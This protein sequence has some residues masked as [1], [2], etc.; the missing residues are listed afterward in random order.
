M[1]GTWRDGEENPEPMGL[2]GDDDE[3]FDEG[4]S[5]VDPRLRNFMALPFAGVRKALELVLLAVWKAEKFWPGV[6]TGP[7]GDMLDCY[8]KQRVSNDRKA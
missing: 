8:W 2:M 6:K 3:V 7:K 1:R 5:G 4:P